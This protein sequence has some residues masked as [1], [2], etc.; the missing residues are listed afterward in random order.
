MDASQVTRTR[1]S[2]ADF[3]LSA[4]ALLDRVPL[5][6]PAFV[7]RWGVAVVFFRSFLVKMDSWQTTIMLFENEYNVPI[8]PPVLAAYMAAAIEFAAPIMLV[9]GLGTRLA[10][11]AMF[12]MTLVIQ[13]FVYPGSWPD[14]LLWT[15]PLLY[16]ILRGPGAWSVDAV[17]RH[18][19]DPDS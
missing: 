3:G 6:L 17:I 10:A 7:L 11:A 1:K 8:L 18:H 15:G 13:L 19:F 9:L 2:M 16:L 12:G 5:A 4:T 14:H